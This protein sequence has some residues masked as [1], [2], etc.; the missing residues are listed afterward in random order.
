MGNLNLREI[1]EQKNKNVPMQIPDEEEMESRLNRNNPSGGNQY[2]GG[3]P[4]PYPNG[5]KNQ[6]T[7]S[8][9]QTRP[10][11]SQ[12]ASSTS[13]KESNSRTGMSDVTWH[14][15]LKITDFITDLIKS[16]VVILGILAANIADTVMGSIAI[17]L[18]VR[19]E[20]QQYSNYS[21]VN[22]MNF[23]VI[24]SLGASSIQIYMWSLIQK[25]NISFKTLVNPKNW[26]YLPK[27]VGGFLAFAGLLWAIDTFLDV[28]PMFV[29][30]TSAV[31]GSTG[32]YPYLVAGVTII[33]II[34]CGFAEI[35]TSNMRGM[36]GLQSPK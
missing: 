10:T 32:L 35:L 6:K 12:P 15:V 25:K 8:P 21:W 16:S 5:G 2:G 33:V 7:Q 20:I 11:Y 18:L 31:Y 23:G 13:Y 36:F 19:P 14:W 27:E 1:M 9:T 4:K 34:L 30:Y 17:S 22:P 28:S 29:F 24:L 3:Y 26:R